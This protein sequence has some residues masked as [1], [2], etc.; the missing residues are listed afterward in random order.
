MLRRFSMYGFLK[1]QRYFEPFFLLAM[2]DKLG[3]V[4]GLAPWLL[5]DFRSPRRLHP[6]WQKGY[7]RKGIIDEQGRR[8]LAFR[9]LADYY[10]GK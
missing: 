3:F 1:N 2:F 9:V 7:N 5:V 8:K 4:K 6:R 10:A